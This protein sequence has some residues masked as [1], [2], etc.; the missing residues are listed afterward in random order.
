[1]TL[2]PRSACGPPLWRVRPR[3]NGHQ[4]DTARARRSPRAPVQLSV[5]CGFRHGRQHS[6]RLGA[7]YLRLAPK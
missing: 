2:V 7:A 1:M 3:A 5:G 6:G 4:C